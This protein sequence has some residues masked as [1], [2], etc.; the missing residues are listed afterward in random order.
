MVGLSPRARGVDVPGQRPEVQRG[1]IPAGAGSRTPDRCAYGT[2][3]DYPRAS[4]EQDKTIDRA[5]VFS[6]PSPRARR[7]DR[8]GSTAVPGAGAIP[9]GAGG[10]GL[11][12]RRR[13]PGRGSPPRARGAVRVGPSAVISAPHHGYVDCLLAAI[14][15][16][17]VTYARARSP[18]HG[19][20]GGR[21]ERPPRGGR[22]GM[23]D[24]PS[25]P[26]QRRAY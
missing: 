1:T 5:G 15:G 20:I 19:R 8:W 7:A 6:G 25:S 21:S 18:H 9:A 17:R 10:A 11:P 2:P 23:R 26:S 16:T 14:A 13:T 12:R 4:G 3:R 22:F 24:S